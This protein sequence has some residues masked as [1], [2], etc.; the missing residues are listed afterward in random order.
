MWL[1][2]TLVNIA[3]LPVSMVVDSVVIPLSGWE[4]SLTAE[5]VKRIT[6]D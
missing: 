5:N 1:F 2:S 4:R 6:N 3:T